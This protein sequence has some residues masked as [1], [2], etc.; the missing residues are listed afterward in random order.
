MVT[1]ARNPHQFLVTPPLT[2]VGGLQVLP[3]SWN[4]AYLATENL[5]LLSFRFGPERGGVNA[6]R[7]H[8]A[9]AR[10]LNISDMTLVLCE[11]EAVN[12]HQVGTCD[13]I[14]SWDQTH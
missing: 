1:G 8:V 9:R 2:W 11:F 7:S 10:G 3:G 12:F 5:R 13:K 14:L 6:V 4:P